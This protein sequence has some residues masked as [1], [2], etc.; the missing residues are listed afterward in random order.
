MIF[1][2]PLEQAY[3]VLTTD[4]IDPELGET[5]HRFSDMVDVWKKTIQHSGFTGLYAGFGASVLGIVVYRSLYFLLYDASRWLFRG[6]RAYWQM[7]AVGITV[8]IAS[9][10][11]AYPLDTIKFVLQLLSSLLSHDLVAGIE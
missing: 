10:F 6:R 5:S 11:A 2:L 3:L 7:F 9:G 8:T 4:V 1:L